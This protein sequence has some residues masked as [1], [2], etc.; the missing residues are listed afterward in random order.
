MGAE[1]FGVQ[2]RVTSEEVPTVCGALLHTPQD[3]DAL[4]IPATGSGRTALYLDAIR[5]C[6]THIQNRPVI[7][8]MIGPFSLAGRL[9]DMTEIMINCYVEPNMVHTTLQKATEFLINCAHAFRQAGIL[10]AEPASRRTP[11]SLANSSC[12]QAYSGLSP[13]SYHACRAHKKR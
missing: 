2:I 3:A 11:L 10:I 12:C 6:S 5:S 9:M 13:P 1:A 4:K 8:G 7:A